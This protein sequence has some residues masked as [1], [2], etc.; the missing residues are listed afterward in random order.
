MSP[1]RP[2]AN[3]SLVPSYELRYLLGHVAVGFGAIFSNAA[4]QKWE[5]SNKYPDPA[6]NPVSQAINNPAI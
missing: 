5:G 2:D 4:L 3:Q 1:V 6:G